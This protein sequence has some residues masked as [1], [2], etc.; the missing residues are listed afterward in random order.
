MADYRSGVQMTVVSLRRYPVKSMGGESLASA[1]LDTRGLCGDR[2][3]A[4]EDEDGHFASGK[5]TR[6]FRRRD[7]VF[8]YTASTNDTGQVVVACGPR[9]WKVGDP[10]LDDELSHV[11]GAPVRVAPEVA[12]PHQDMGAVSI[13][14]TATL[15][16]CA[17]RWGISSDPRRLR[18]NILFTSDQP[19]IEEKW[20]GSE[21]RV[22]GVKL[23][24]VEPVPRCRMID[25]D[26]DDARTEGRWLKPLAAERDMFLAM[27]ADVAAT[28][29]I[30]VGDTLTVG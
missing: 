9:A 1:R 12:I 10:A 2:W 27:Y 4:V 17:Q 3:F 18:V 16:W 30:R 15:D 8:N 6:R 21:V 7:A 23:R 19:F 25:I 24:V 28:G 29:V 22:G 11:M 14:S 5:N 13:I 20:V 26:Q